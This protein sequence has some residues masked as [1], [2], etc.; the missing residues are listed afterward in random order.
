LTAASPVHILTNMNILENKPMSGIDR[1]FRAFADPTRL[2][3]LHLLLAG[4]HCVSDI[5][6]ILGAPQ[7]KVSH[8]L[9]Y[10]HGAG[11]VEVRKEGLWCFYQ[12]RPA[13]SPFHATLIECLGHCFASV[14]ELAAD[15]ERAA[16]VR[17]S[18]GCCPR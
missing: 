5:V 1:M 12:L 11:L 18:G 7:A 14:P 2:R 10:L 6:S 15:R 13:Q 9:K 16:K 17:A 4:E 3:I 8:H